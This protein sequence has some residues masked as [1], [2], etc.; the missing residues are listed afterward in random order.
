MKPLAQRFLVKSSVLLNIVKALVMS[1]VL[2]VTILLMLIFP[3][4]KLRC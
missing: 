3:L 1:I 4:S 2:V